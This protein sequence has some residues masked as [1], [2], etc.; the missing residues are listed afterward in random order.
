MAASLFWGG[1]RP[2]FLMLFALLRCPFY[3]PLQ[4]H[5]VT[6]GSSDAQT[7]VL[8]H[9][10]ECSHAV[11]CWETAV[12]PLTP[13]CFYSCSCSWCCCK[14]RSL[15]CLG[16]PDLDAL[17]WVVARMMMLLLCTVQGYFAYSPSPLRFLTCRAEWTACSDLKTISNFSCVF[18]SVSKSAR[19]L[20]KSIM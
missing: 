20:F 9:S 2:R 19:F 10:Q 7:D 17:E 18:A 6:S 15:Y 16:S 12:Y 11:S 3:L 4:A 14:W 1:V 13:L 8:D 5:L